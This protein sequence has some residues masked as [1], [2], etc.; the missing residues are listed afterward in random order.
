[1]GFETTCSVVVML[2]V[3]TTL[4]RARN[5]TMA[6]P[7]RGCAVHV[8]GP[9]SLNRNGGCRNVATVTQ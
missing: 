2:L 4:E 5:S 8:P 6:S 7:R 9:V 3:E 1:M